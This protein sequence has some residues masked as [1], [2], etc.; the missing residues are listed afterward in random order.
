MRSEIWKEP[1]RV[2]SSGSRSKAGKKLARVIVLTPAAAALIHSAPRH[3][4]AFVFGGD[5]PLKDSFLADDAARKAAALAYH[6]TPHMFRHLVAT[7]LREQGEG[8]DAVRGVLGQQVQGA[9]AITLAL[10]LNRSCA[11]H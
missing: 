10:H 2:S 9:L 5:R 4:G 7:W 1:M 8:A 3:S 6:W 11:Q